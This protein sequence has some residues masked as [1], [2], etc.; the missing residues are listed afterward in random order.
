MFAG[1]APGRGA[2]ARGA[3]QRPGPAAG[4]LQRWA[5]GAAPARRGGTPA[6]APS[7]NRARLPCGAPWWELPDACARARA[8]AAARM[9]RGGCTSAPWASSPPV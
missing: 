3:A 2:R 1:Q 7:R 6:E 8:S 4:L 5:A 9:V